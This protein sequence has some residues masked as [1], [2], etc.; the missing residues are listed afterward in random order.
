MDEIAE[1]LRWLRKRAKSDPRQQL[2][3]LGSQ[4]PQM[5]AC[6]HFRKSYKWY[7]FACCGR[8][9]P[10]PECHVESGCPA[11]ALGAHASRMICGKCSMEQAYSPARAC[12]KCGFSMQ[13]KGSAHWEDGAGTRNL[14]TMSSKDAKKFKG[15]LR[16]SN[17][18]AK[19]S[20]AKADRV[21]AK[22]KAKREHN[23]KFGKAG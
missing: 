22:A 4:L 3:K 17:S 12:E 15:G 13:P 5:G 14:A 18:K 20:S 11:A 8:A 1:E 9:F 10:C 6:R 7:R 19:T 23:Q 21:G 16:Q 2:I